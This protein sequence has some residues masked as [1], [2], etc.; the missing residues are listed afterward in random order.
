MREVKG[1][2]DL[3]ATCQLII[4]LNQSSEPEKIAIKVKIGLSEFSFQAFSE[5]Y[6]YTCP[7]EEMELLQGQELQ[8][9]T[10]AGLI[11]LDRCVPEHWDWELV[12]VSSEATSIISSVASSIPS[13]VSQ[14]SPSP[15]SINYGLPAGLFGPPIQ[16]GSAGFGDTE[17]WDIGNQAFKAFFESDVSKKTLAFGFNSATGELELSDKTKIKPGLIVALA[18]D[19]YGDPEHPISVDLT[20]PTPRM[21]DLSKPEEK[22]AAIAAFEVAYQ[23]LSEAHDTKAAKKKFEDYFKEIQAVQLDPTIRQG[24]HEWEAYVKALDKGETP[25]IPRY[26]QVSELMER[27]SLAHNLNCHKHTRDGVFDSEYLRMLASNYDHFGELG[28]LAYQVGHEVAL[29]AACKAHKAS[30]PKEKKHLLH[31][32]MGLELFAAHFLTD[33][34]A[35]GHMRVP[36]LALVKH[37]KAHPSKNALY[38]TLFK[39]K[40][41]DT[42]LAGLLVNAMHDEENRRPLLVMNLNEAQKS[43][44]GEVNSGAVWK[45][46][47]DYYYFDVDNRENRKRVIEALAKQLNVVFTA[48]ETGDKPAEDLTEIFPTPLAVNR[49][50]MFRVKADGHVQVRHAVSNPDGQEIYRDTWDPFETYIAAVGKTE[51]LNKLYFVLSTAASDGLHLAAEKTTDELQR[52]AEKAKGFLSKLKGCLTNISDRSL[53]FIQ[54]QLDAL[55][56]ELDDLMQE[57]ERTN[58]ARLSIELGH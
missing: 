5:G 17:H 6:Y 46:Y 48:Y 4:K 51:A 11:A 28:Q 41:D 27:H 58:T 15:S 54:S 1:N 40:L 23:T 18:G 43:Q 7:L 44:R 52:I 39:Y 45:A 50:P 38:Q 13:V 34:Y 3:P 31:R 53:N 24:I 22:E 8:L 25:S 26:K 30:E 14:Q 47:G 55:W 35:S 16:D 36:R 49:N 21:R 33:N 32:A 42:K 57:V 37:V 29:Q 19:F 2:Q 9:E 20:G 12:R 56:P 10:Q